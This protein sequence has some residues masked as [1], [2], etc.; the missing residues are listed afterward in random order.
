ML[1]AFSFLCLILTFVV[2]DLRSSTT[3]QS[4]DERQIEDKIPKHLPIKIR[5]QPEKEKAVKDLNN[6]RWHHDIAFEVKN[7]GDKPIYYLSFFLDM[8]EIKPDGIIVGAHLYYGQRSIFGEWKGMAQPE[9]VP[10]RPNETIVLTLGKLQADGWDERSKIEKLPQ[11]NKLSMV[12]QELNFGDGTG[13]VG[14]TGAPWPIPKRASPPAENQNTVPA[15]LSGQRLH[16]V[17][18]NNIAKSRLKR[19]DWR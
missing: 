10:L 12:F 9:D 5:I 7:I 16:H 14:G 15:S 3:A 2:N 4:G 11:P 6:G 19:T 17:E 13:F 18:A 1:F 8:P